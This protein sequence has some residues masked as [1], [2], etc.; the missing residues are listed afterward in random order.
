MS[1]TLGISNLIG[2]PWQ[3]DAL[4]DSWGGSKEIRNSQNLE[5]RNLCSFKTVSRWEMCVAARQGIFQP[6]YFLLKFLHCLLFCSQLTL[7]QDIYTFFLFYFCLWKASP[8][9]LF[10]CITLC[11]KDVDKCLKKSAVHLFA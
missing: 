6:S 10:F 9:D 2:Q 1:W 11:A 8:L 4:L 5:L 3:K 7:L